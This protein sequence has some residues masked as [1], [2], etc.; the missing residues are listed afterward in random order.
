[1]VNPARQKG[2]RFEN[3]VLAGLRTVWPEV[4]RAK[5]GNESNDFSGAP[6]PI[7]AKHRKRWDIHGWVAKLR[8]ITG[9]CTRWALVAAPGDRREAGAPPAL[10]IV[11]FQFGLELLA[12][13][14]HA[15]DP[16]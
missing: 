14:E 5:A 9:G 12:A 1:M 4:D 10:M 16:P 6:F 2:T 15:E 13:W 8:K 3:E 11:D 7:E